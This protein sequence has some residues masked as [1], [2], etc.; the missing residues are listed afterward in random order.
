MPVEPLVRIRCPSA[1]DAA[2][3][4][5]IL[6]AAGLAPEES[7]SWLVVRDASPDAVNDLLVSGGAQGRSVAREQV[8]KLLGYLLDR[9]GDLAG[10][11]PNLAQIVRRALS[12]TGLSGRYAPRAE[13]ELLSAA[14]ELH[15]YLLAS[16]G[17]FVPW[18]RFVGAF[19]V[20]R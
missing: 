12:E 15:E 6:S 20:P 10:R 18:E 4:R 17:G 1:E 16:A 7:L 14:A 9:Q 13:P 8:G 11:G 19:C 2:R 5:A 3:C